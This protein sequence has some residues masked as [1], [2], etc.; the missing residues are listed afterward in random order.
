MLCDRAGEEHA[1]Q[2]A[3][4]IA[5]RL[6]SPSR[7]LGSEVRG[8]P[9]S[10]SR[11]AAGIALLHVERALV[12]TGN[13]ETAH[14]WLSAAVRDDIDAGFD[15]SLLFGAPAL[16]FA[17]HAAAESGRYARACAALRAGVEALT[18]Q[19][20][21]QAHA[22]I[23]RSDRPP[24]REFDSFHG[25]TGI[26]IYLLA[27]NPCSDL[28][29]DVLAY[30]VRL[31]QPLPR[32]REGLPGWWSTLAPTGKLSPAFPGGHGNVGIAH[33]ISGPLALLS[34][35]MRRGVVID[36]H[37]DAIGRICAWL[38]TW[39]REHPSGSRWPEK[40][41]LD[42]MH[43]QQCKHTV[44]LRPSWC[45]GTPGIARAQQLAAIATGDIAR[46][47]MAEA[48]LLGCL[49]DPAQLA[50]VTDG[51]LCHGAAGLFQTIW[52]AAADATTPA[53]RAHLPFL[54][55]I[56]LDRYEASGESP[57]LLSGDAGV[58]LA[59]QTAATDTAPASGWDACLLLA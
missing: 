43:R 46:Q 29:H 55:G 38:D 16:A 23:D 15:A 47:Q 42:A 18:R 49:S 37:T 10:L 26:G 11:G 57:S 22:R 34:L 51:G 5:A 28:M 24:L 53:L 3:D 20:L 58:A 54:L 8:L 30:L 48:A 50:R 4:T 35:S 12:G 32:E 56:L 36:G 40:I 6:A 21:A 52:R 13:W 7:A 27:S 59:L 17:V 31:S 19:R 25:L 2:A 41:T 1:R 14:A 33:G 39:R 9:Q 44:P 45:Y